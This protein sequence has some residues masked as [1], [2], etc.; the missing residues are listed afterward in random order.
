MARQEK[1][2]PSTKKRHS[3]REGTPT[4]TYR[5]REVS[6]A[7]S[8]LAPVGEKPGAESRDEP[9]GRSMAALVPDVAPVAPS[10]RIAPELEDGKARTMRRTAT[11]ARRTIAFIVQRDA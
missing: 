7:L 8:D 10:K 4:T 9:P 2:S 3:S 1:R 11:P 6:G 5:L